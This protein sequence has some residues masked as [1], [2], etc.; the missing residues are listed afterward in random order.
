MSA[1]RVEGASRSSDT[2]AHADGGA[3]LQGQGQDWSAVVVGVLPD[4][5]DPPR[6]GNRDEGLGGERF[7][8][9]AYSL[10]G[11]GNADHKRHHR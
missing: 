11:G 7:V 10:A 2:A 6:G 4:E 3:T 1:T 5:G 9:E 8:V